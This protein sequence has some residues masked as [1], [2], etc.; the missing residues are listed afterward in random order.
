MKLILQPKLDPNQ[1]VLVLGIFEED[2]DYYKSYN[3]DLSKE[4]AE[5]FKR[6]LFSSEFGTFYST[7]I[8]SLPFQKVI[9]AGLGKEKDLSIEQLRNILG[10]SVKQIRSSKFTSFTTNIP[11]L[12]AAVKGLNEE[13]AGR[14]VAEALLLANYSFSKYLSKDRLD[15]NK[16][17][18]EVSLL[19][20]NMKS[21]FTAGLKTGRVIAEATNLVRELVEDSANVINST[22]LEKVVKEVAAKHNSKI[23]VK[24]LEEAELKKLGMGSLLGVNAGS[25][26]P[27]KLILIEYNGGSGKPIALVGKGITFDSG[28]Y[29]L[30]PTKYIEDMKTDMAGAAAVLGTIKVAAE[31]GIKKNLLGVM[32]LCE[33]MVSGHAQRPGDIVKAYNG[34]TIEIGNTDAEGRL[35]LADA[36]AY[37]EDKYQPAVMI[38]LATLT[39][40]CVVA[41]G[42][43]AAAVISKDEKLVE[44][45]RTAGMASG[46]R[47]WPLPLFDDFQ[48]WMDGTI[49]DL[50]NISQKGK[51]YEAG[52][53]TAAVFLNKFV[54]RTTWAHLDIAGSA[55]WGVEGDYLQ[56][57]A[58]GSGVRVLS[59]WLLDN[60]I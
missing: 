13:M 6:K 51:G 23:K 43:Y 25:E 56:K 53:I 31:L 49:T 59:Y 48:N 41:L 17:L 11:K 33:N 10:K 40:A 29:N 52:S 18:I 16:P 30:K 22:Y 57:G 1:E 55:Y 27:P 7:K 21:P 14:A 8:S 26:N 4:I 12:A 60:Q 38:D 39:G 19:W 32:P 46:D 47:V 54:E 34:K 35:I 9:L 50:N 28:G 3:L 24:V 2:K 5:A 45:L 44:D 36:L 15:K 58:T 20:E 42:Y 37:T